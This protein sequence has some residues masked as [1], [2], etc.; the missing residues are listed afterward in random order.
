MK[1]LTKGYDANHLIFAIETMKT[2][3]TNEKE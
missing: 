2:F 1:K 3:L